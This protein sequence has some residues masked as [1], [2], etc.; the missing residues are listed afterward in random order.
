VQ[1]GV[2]GVGAAALLLALTTDWRGVYVAEALQ[3]LASSL[4]APG[5]AAISLAAV[6]HSAFG[7]RIGRN[8]RFASIGSGLTAGAMGL[9]SG[10][11]RC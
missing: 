3:G 2:M 11:R 4:I 7:E 8:A 6:G 5:I 10:S 1:A 9:A